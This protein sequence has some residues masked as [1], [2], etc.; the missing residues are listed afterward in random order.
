M[1]HHKDACK[2]RAAEIRDEI[3]SKQPESSHLGDCP[4]CL[5]TLYLDYDDSTM[6][7]CCS[8]VICEGMRRINATVLAAIRHSG[9][10]C[11]YVGDF[12]TAFEYVTPMQL[13]WAMSQLFLSSSYDVLGW[14][15]F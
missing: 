2:K 14:K 3:L 8:K 7:S 15:M 13:D 9:I 1:P 11:Y 4:I 6:M 5:L 12:V 10:K